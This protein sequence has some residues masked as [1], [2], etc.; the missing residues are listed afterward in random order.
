MRWSW[1]AVMLV[2]GVTQAEIIDRIAIIADNDA[3]LDSDIQ[4][5]IRLTSF[6]NSKAPD[7]SPASR[8]A[9]ASRLVDQDLIRKQIRSGVYPS[10][11]RAQVDAL[12]SQ[13]RHDRFL[14][15]TEFSQAL[16]RNGIT[17]AQLRDR[18]SWQLTVLAFIDARF[19]PEV[20]ISNKDINDYMTSHKSA[21]PT[22]AQVRELITGER[23]NKL[24]NSW[25]D[26][27]RKD[28]RVEYLEKS[29]K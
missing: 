4:R 15:D 8:K 9:A 5:D 25:L 28:T 7:F 17:E 24:L 22:E 18:L 14:S 23:V 19:R 27:A 13:I 6:L 29:L 16:A 11:S 12:L 3:I 26:D 10:A 21:N 20:T 2:Y 1:I